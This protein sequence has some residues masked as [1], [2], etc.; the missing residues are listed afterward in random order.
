[1]PRVRFFQLL[2]AGL[3]GLY[4]PAAQAANV[5]VNPVR[6]YLS[7]AKRSELIELRNS[8]V[9]PARFQL[10]ASAWHESTDGEMKLM[11]TRDLLFFPSLLEIAPGESKR[12]RVA[13]TVPPGRVERT[14][15]LIAEEFPRAPTP[16]TVQ[17][18][19]RLSIPVFVQPDAPKPRPAVDATVESG[20]LVV[21][22]ANTG[23]AAFKADS[24]RVVARSASGE[25][26]FE[27]SVSGWYVLASG[28]RRYEM[29]LPRGSCREITGL[30]VSARTDAGN[31]GFV[32][33]L[34]P[35]AGCGG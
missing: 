30:D 28:R 3:L 11:P 32:S 18:L 25:V 21:F 17:V 27:Q 16:G 1:M 31:A 10:Q 34:R 5:T 2:V 12:V 26:L 19:T 7:G 15:R 13:S 20:R 4:V 8:G 29:D 24:V 33:Q 6:I 23:N 22:V 9:E 14:Y 35:G